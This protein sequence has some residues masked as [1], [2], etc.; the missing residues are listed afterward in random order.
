LI[1]AT[2]EN[3]S[4]TVN[5]A[6]LSR[7]RLFVFEKITPEEVYSFLVSQKEKIHKEYPDIEVPEDV[8]NFL[9]NAANGDLRNAINLLES[10][11]LLL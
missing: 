8:L 9:S 10:A 11:L 3:P 6:L 1:G 4:F 5:N 7:C 2:T